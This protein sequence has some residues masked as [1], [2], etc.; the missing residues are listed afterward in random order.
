VELFESRGAR[1]FAAATGAEAIEHVR[2]TRPQVI[3]SDIGL[4]GEDGLT[5]LRELRE[6]HGARGIP[7][8]ALTAYVS[9]P[10]RNAVLAAGFDVHVPKPV[11][12]QQLLGAI[13]ALLGRSTSTSE[14]S[15]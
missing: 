6:R 1:V 8:V 14:S 11:D 4:A 13:A 7:A 12:V 2:A 9:P 10:D 5:L 3:V 15:K